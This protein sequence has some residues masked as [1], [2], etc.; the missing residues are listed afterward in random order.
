MDDL[1]SIHRRVYKVSGNNIISRRQIEQIK[2]D[3]KID[4]CRTREKRV[5]RERRPSV[6]SIAVTTRIARS[7]L[8]ATVNDGYYCLSSLNCRVHVV[9]YTFI[10]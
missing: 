9:E 7:M 8:L 5:A 4:E 1:S 2:L 3:R 10:L 6:T